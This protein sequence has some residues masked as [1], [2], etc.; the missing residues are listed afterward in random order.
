MTNNN[1][2]LAALQQ[3]IENDAVGQLRRRYG[4]MATLGSED[5]LGT[6]F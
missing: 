2:R 3:L 4:F 6:S 5:A 1:A